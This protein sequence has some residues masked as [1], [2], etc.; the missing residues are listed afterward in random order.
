MIFE[1]AAQA[2][3]LFTKR[4]RT[5]S[6]ALFP[7]F[8]QPLFLARKKGQS[9]FNGRQF[10]LYDQGHKLR[11]RNFQGFLEEAVSLPVLPPAIQDSF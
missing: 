1:L 4:A 9:K 7:P 10:V 6:P 8:S 11:M 2:K 5:A 3:F